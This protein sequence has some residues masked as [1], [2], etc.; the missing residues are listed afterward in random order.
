VKH[1]YIRGGSAAEIAA[2]IEEAIHRGRIAAGEALP[3]VRRLATELGVSPVTVAAGYKQLRLRGLAAGA[4]RLGT[5]VAPRPPSPTS[6]R[7]APQPAGLA[8]LASGNPDPAFLPSLDAALRSIVVAPR[9]YGEP[10]ELRPLM[11][12][13]QQEFESDGVP[14]GAL[15]VVGGALDGIERILRDHLRPGD[16]VAVED[17]CFPGILDLLA[18]GNLTRV[19]FAVDDEGPRA[20]EFEEALR[21]SRAAIVTPRGQNPFGAALTEARALE[22]RKVLKEHA[23]VLYVENDP[24]SA[25]SGAPPITLANA[26]TRHWAVVRS[27]SKFL[28]PDLRLA[29]VA[30]DELTIARVEGRQ[31]LGTRWVSTILQQLALALWSDPSSGRL[32]ARAT[33]VYRHRR[34]ALLSALRGHGIDAHGRA[35]FNVWI[36]VRDEAPVVQALAECGWAVMAGERFRLRTPPAIRVTVSALE[37]LDAQRFAG[38]LQRAMASAARF[39]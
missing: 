35:G 28:G 12:F 31:A 22:L 15:T 19:P 10:A 24:V 30:G 33:E 11:T 34:Q 29:G 25:V 39:A 13:L 1:K 20:A 27:T 4:G 18:A 16:A 7:L 21:R 17:P 9:L 14:G 26:G 36:P 32:L 3:P 23:Q 37:P 8:D 5:R 2:S 6:R 38:D